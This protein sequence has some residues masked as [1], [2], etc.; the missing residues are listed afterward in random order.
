MQICG[1]QI[2]QKLGE[3]KQNKTFWHFDFD[4]SGLFELEAQSQWWKYPPLKTQGPILGEMGENC[5][6]QSHQIL[7]TDTVKQA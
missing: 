4:P 1:S 6:P 3:K 5:F 2:L 7:G